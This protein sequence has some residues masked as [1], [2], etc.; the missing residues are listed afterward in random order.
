MA[1]TSM[2]VLQDIDR[3]WD[4]KEV[5]HFLHLSESQIYALVSEEKIPFVRIG[6]S[7]RFDPYEIAKFI[8]DCSADG[9]PR[10]SVR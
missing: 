5:A 3:L 6:K 7:I 2:S 8:S 4:V 9:S 10:L 1:S